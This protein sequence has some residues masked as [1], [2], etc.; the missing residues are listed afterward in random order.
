MFAQFHKN[1][2][3]TV[4]D[5]SWA[6]QADPYP[7]SFFD[8]NNA[9]Q[10]KDWCTALLPYL[11]GM[12][13]NGQTLGTSTV[14]EIAQY[15]KVF[16]CPSDQWLS[17]PVPGYAMINNVPN[18]NP[19]PGYAYSLYPISYGINADIAMITY[20]NQYGVFSAG[21]GN[22]YSIYAGPAPVA[23]ESIPLGCRID[24]VYKASETLLFA[25]CGTRPHDGSDQVSPL[26][27][28][29]GLCFSTNYDTTGG[30]LQ[31]YNPASP[32]A[33]KVYGTL[34]GLANCWWLGD[35]FPVAEFMGHI[36][37]PS[38]NRHRSGIINV[39]FCDGHVESLHPPNYFNTTTGWSGGDYLRVRVSPWPF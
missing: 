14:Q 2:I 32:Y 22:S 4:S 12:S 28:N 9:G 30:G 19:L 13:A 34:L 21:T 37:G 29:Y 39:A 24:R 1:H 31:N 7:R 33:P 5:T 16:Q 15:T 8:Y 25:D 17:D 26:D 35:R 18:T 11:G 27:Y 20:N 36:L 6:V 38:Y 3:P 10:V 23:G